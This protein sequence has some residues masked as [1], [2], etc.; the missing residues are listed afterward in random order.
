MILDEIMAEIKRI[1]LQEYGVVPKYINELE[2][3]RP[4]IEYAKLEID[5][6][7]RSCNYDNTEQEVLNVCKKKDELINKI[8]ELEGKWT[9]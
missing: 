7:E 6:Y 2:K 8:K 4:Y 3:L 1:Y 9:L 5:W